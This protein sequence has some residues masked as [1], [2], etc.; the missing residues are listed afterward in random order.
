MD[1]RS[2]VLQRLEKLLEGFADKGQSSVME[3]TQGVL[4]AKIFVQTHSITAEELRQIANTAGLEA[5]QWT[6]EG[7]QALSA[8]LES[9]NTPLPPG[10]GSLPFAPLPR[11]TPWQSSLPEPPRRWQHVVAGL[12]LVVLVGAAIGLRFVLIMF[13]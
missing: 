2:N 13:R 12:A 9:R 6:D 10:A 8:W 1:T 11:S 4:A 7:N 3:T 5:T